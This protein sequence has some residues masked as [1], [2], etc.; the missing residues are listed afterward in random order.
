MDQSLSETDVIYGIT[1]LCKNG[2]LGFYSVRPAARMLMLLE[3]DEWVIRSLL[4]EICSMGRELKCERKTFGNKFIDKISFSYSKEFEELLTSIR[5][6][7]FQSANSDEERNE[8]KILSGFN[9]RSLRGYRQRKR[10]FST[11]GNR[12]FGR[13]GR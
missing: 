12:F 11:N 6:T 1:E 13:R 7:A 10:L 2:S 9:S 5:E 3:K 4:H 8:N